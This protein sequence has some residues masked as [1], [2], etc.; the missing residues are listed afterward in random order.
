MTVIRGDKKRPQKYEGKV[1]VIC[2]DSR[3][4]DIREFD[5][6]KYKLVDFDSQS[7][8]EFKN[9]LKEDNNPPKLVDS[10]KL[11]LLKDFLAYENEFIYFALNNGMNYIIKDTHGKAIGDN[12]KNK[13]NLKA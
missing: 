5:K 9:P 6:F 3:D 1:I 13:W 8:S 11:K 10:I 4:P 7:I 2:A 12:D